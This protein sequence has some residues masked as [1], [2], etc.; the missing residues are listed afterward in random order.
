MTDEE[1]RPN[2]AADSKQTTNDRA[3]ALDA[4]A[5]VDRIQRLQA[6]FENYKKRVAR[7]TEERE[8]RAVDRILLD[9]LP[10]HD[11]LQLAFENY[12]RDGDSEAFVSGVERIF[13]QFEEIL[14]SKGVARIDAMGKAFD[15]ALHEALMRLASDQEKNVIVE[16]F[17]PGYVRN[18]RTLRPSRVGVSQ[19]PGQP[20]EEEE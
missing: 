17:S 7:E 5:L 6:E 16:V 3:E 20:T 10:L 15:P 18:G 8:E 1:R 11:G 19:G 13:A 4:G 9:V 14:E 12:Y 2:G